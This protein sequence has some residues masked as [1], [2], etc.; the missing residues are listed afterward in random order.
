MLV[1]LRIIELVVV[2]FFIVSYFISSRIIK[3][4][5]KNMKQQFSNLLNVVG[6]IPNILLVWAIYKKLGK[7][8]VDA[9]S[10]RTCLYALFFKEEYQNID[11]NKLCSILKWIFSTP[12]SGGQAVVEFDKIV[13]KSTQTEEYLVS[14]K[15][16][17]DRHDVLIKRAGFSKAFALCKAAIDWNELVE[18]DFNLKEDK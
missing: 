13:D 14:L 11:D 2:S 18:T 7:C 15:Y 10:D 6:E 12:K 17:N 3:F 4:D 9:I 5:N 1:L 8:D 16:S